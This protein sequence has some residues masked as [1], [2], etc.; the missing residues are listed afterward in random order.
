MPRSERAIFLFLL[1]RGEGVVGGGGVKL[2]QGL[3]DV[4]VT[5]DMCVCVCL[6]F[7]ALGSTSLSVRGTT[8]LQQQF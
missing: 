7:D 4:Y 2:S 5:H 3:V 6:C 8:S 1:R